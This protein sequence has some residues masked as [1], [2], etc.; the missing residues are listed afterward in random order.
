VKNSPLLKVLRT[1]RQRAF[2][3]SFGRDVVSAVCGNGFLQ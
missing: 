1:V 3:S 2:K